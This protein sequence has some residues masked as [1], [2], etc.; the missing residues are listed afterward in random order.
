[1]SKK[2]LSGDHPAI[3]ARGLVKVYGENWV[4]GRHPLLAFTAIH[5]ERA[6]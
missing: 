4:P 5:A 2:G 3:G 6:D 1:M